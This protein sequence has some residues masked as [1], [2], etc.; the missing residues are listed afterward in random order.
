[1]MAST[2]SDPHPASSTT[3]DGP[4]ADDIASRSA[5]MRSGAAAGR[6]MWASGELPTVGRAG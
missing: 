5:R 2:P 6:I 3:D 4:I 1:M